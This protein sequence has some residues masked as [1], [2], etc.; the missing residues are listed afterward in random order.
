M[1]QIDPRELMKQQIQMQQQLFQQQE[2][3]KEYMANQQQQFLMT[4]QK[5]QEN[6]VQKDNVVKEILEDS[7]KK[8][9]STNALLEMMKN[10]SLEQTLQF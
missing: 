7:K 6:F 3:F 10:Q 1:E 4:L 9:E 2:N 8:E 5:Q